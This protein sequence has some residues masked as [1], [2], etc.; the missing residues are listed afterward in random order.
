MWRIDKPSFF[1]VLLAQLIGLGAWCAVSAQAAPASTELT[2]GWTLISANSATNSGAVI[3]QVGYSTTN[4]YPITVPSTVMA[5]LVANAFYTNLFMGTNMLAVPDLTTQKWWFRTQIVAPPN[6]GGQYW[7]RFKGI[8]Y[9]AE[10]WL[11]GTQLDAAAE[12]SLVVHEYNVTSLLKPGAA[13]VIAAR[14]TPPGRLSSSYVTST[15]LSHTFVDWNPSVPDFGAG[16]WGKVILDTSGP[17]ELRDPYVKTVLPLPAID[18]AD[19]T[20]YVD[21]V[22]GTASAVNGT[23]QATITKPGYP[24]I[25]VQQTVAL[26]ANERREVAFAPATFTQLHVSNPTLWWPFEMGPAELYDLNVSFVAAGQTSASQSIKFGI[27]QVTQSHTPPIYGTAYFQSFQVNGRNFLVRGGGY[28]WDIFMRWN[29][30]TNEAHIKY[31]KDMGLNTIRFEGTLGNEELYDIADREGVMLMPGFVCCMSRWESWSTWTTNEASVANA[32]LDSQMRNMRAHASALVWLYGS[33]HQPTDV[34]PYYVLT[35]Y[36]N[37]A[38]KLHWQNA[39]VNS[40]ATDGIK[41]RGAYKWVAPIYWYQDTN[42]DGAFGICAEEGGETPPPSESLVKFIPADQ[43]W[44]MTFGTVTTPNAYS[45]HAGTSSKYNNINFFNTGLSNRLGAP[46]DLSVYSDRAQLQCYE[47]SRAQFEAFGGNAYDPASGTGTATGTIFWMLNSAWPS[48]HWNLYDYYFKPAGSYFGAKKANEP[49][50]PLWDYNSQKIKVY[51]SSLNAYTGMQL[52]AAV[53]NIPDLGLKYTNH[54]ILNIPADLATEAFTLPVISGL[55]NTWFLRLRLQ[56]ASGSPVSDNLYWYSTKTDAVDYS[57]TPTPVTNYANLT[58]LNALATNRKMTTFGSALVS[59]DQATA[60]ITLT[61]LNST[62]VAFFVRAEVTKGQGGEEV[63]P[64]TYSDNYVSLWPGESTTLTAQYAVA[65]LGGQTAFLRVRGYN[66]P[67]VLATLTTI[68]ITNPAH[69]LSQPISQ[70]TYPAVPASFS[71]SAAGDPPL[72]YQW[73]FNGVDIAGA[74][75]NSFTL[76]SPTIFDAGL[77]SVLVTNASG[78]ELSTD[79]S[80]SIVPLA[81][82]GDNGFDQVTVPPTTINAISIAAGAWH[83]LALRSDTSVLGWGKDSEGQTDVPP[84][85]RN[86]ASLAAG[87]YHSLALK[88]DGTVV[89]WGDNSYGQTNVPPGLSNITAVAAGTWHSLAL[90]ANGTIVAWGDNSWGQTNVPAGL[91]NILAIAGGGNHSLALRADHTVAAWG[92]NTDAEGNYGGQCVP[93]PDLN[94]VVAIAAGAYHS[95]AVKDDGTVVAWGDDSQGQCDPPTG[96][97]NV[98]AV[99]GGGGHT[100]ALKADTT[101]SAW[102]Q[103]WYGQCDFPP[104]LTNIVAVAAGWTHTLLLQG[105]A[106]APPRLL[107]PT[108]ADQ[109]FKAVLLTFPGQYYALE[110]QTNLTEHAWTVLS[111]NAGNGTLQVLTDPNAA[112]APRFYRIRR[113]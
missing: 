92:E 81:A 83:N 106:L 24:T 103:D 50:H 69:L 80:L 97:T 58:G 30:W 22:N 93:P 4:W 72:A 23:L 29:T 44:P 36:K 33:D 49:V 76:A 64:V 40:A 95:L 41:M 16:I 112:T 62:N 25:S 6:P 42:L 96:L 57:T 37:I 21:A 10:I 67:Q 100:V 87:G 78:Y 63:V 13:N 107:W 18:S 35:S 8:S 102:G 11:N 70:T 12:G 52:S 85:L 61:N 71:V 38:S 56:L 19:L 17:V 110:Y 54:V 86:V 75:S 73:R 55:S 20:I 15:N 31:T 109:Q 59:N 60:T 39:T 77:Y 91:T 113:W 7:L 43:L 90:R 98:I 89:A 51:N 46:P 1:G 66:V 32:S 2:Q 108:Y 88:L 65:D 105:D 53:Y 34:A 99:A 9:S 47:A 68:I 28:V 45:Y 5:G 82:R 26:A 27:R 111:T 94:H 3:S 84:G 74:T 48:I 104:A 79:A 14:I 101:V